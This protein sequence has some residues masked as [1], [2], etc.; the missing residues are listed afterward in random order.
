MPHGDCTERAPQHLAVD[1]VELF[2]RGLVQNR[3][4]RCSTD[5]PRQQN[6][7]GN[8]M[9][10]VRRQTQRRALEQANRV[11]WKRLAS[12]AAE[13]TEWQVFSLWLGAVVEAAKCVPAMVVKEVESRA[14]QLIGRIR[15]DV[16]AAVTN[17]SGAGTSIWQDVSQWAE[18]H[19]FATV[20][21]E[22]WLDAVRYFSSMSLRS[23]QA[24]SLWEQTDEQWRVAA[25]KQFPT[26][27]QWQREVAAVI[28]L[29]NPDAM[30]QHLLDSVR[31][32]PEGEWSRLLSGFS[33]LIA[34]CLW[35]ELVLD[36][37]GP[38]SWSVSQELA[39]RYSGFILAGSAI[40]TKE[41]V[42]S[43]NDWAIEHALGIADREHLLTAL[44][45]HIRHQPAYHAMRNYALHCH[46]VWPDECS[47]HPPSFA[48]WR[49]AADAYFET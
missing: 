42:R 24:W 40:G 18:V 23:M 39:M 26:F 32:L 12:A 31:A 34:F 14:P 38:T 41:A 25:P 29:S 9:D 37:E 27:A 8:L 35:M 22:G 45:F 13:Y 20:K 30:A 44:S 4:V 33:D 47:N 43:L 2:G 11:T 7:R 3:T 19:V 16:E 6:Q 28:R 48:E 17:G 46:D 5:M 21:R 15:S 1:P 49:D 10:R 36:M